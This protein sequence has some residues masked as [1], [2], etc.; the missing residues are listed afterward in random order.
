MNFAVSVSD[1]FL[2][3]FVD[4]RMVGVLLFQD[5]FFLD[6]PDNFILRFLEFSLHLIFLLF[7]S[8]SSIRRQWSPRLIRRV[9]IDFLLLN[10]FLNRFLCLLLRNPK[11]WFIWFLIGW[12]RGIILLNLMNRT[13][14]LWLAFV[15]AVTW[16][17]MRHC[18]VKR[19]LSG[20][21]FCQSVE[22]VDLVGYTLG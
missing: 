22:L 21:L 10:L 9:L 1:E 2:R 7:L 11:T 5:F 14:W 20:T 15:S 19:T 6:L 16:G 3:M 8:F 12:G 17:L 4:L 13:T 18:V